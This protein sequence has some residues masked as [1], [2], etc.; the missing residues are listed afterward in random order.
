MNRMTFDP[1]SLTDLDHKNTLGI[2]NLLKTTDSFD[3][4]I[5]LIK[6]NKHGIENV[7][8]QLHN[9]ILIKEKNMF[10]LMV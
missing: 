2:L 10:I 5:I 6:L 7:L 8:K 3:H 9:F 4:K 1:M